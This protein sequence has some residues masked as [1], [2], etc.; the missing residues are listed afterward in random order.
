[1]IVEAD[2]DCLLS[3]EGVVHEAQLKISKKFPPWTKLKNSVGESE[4]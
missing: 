4:G 1:M 2:T 3:V